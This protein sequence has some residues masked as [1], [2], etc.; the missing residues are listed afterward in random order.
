MCVLGTFSEV[1]TVPEVL[2]EA[3]VLLEATATFWY[4]LAEITPIKI[5]DKRVIRTFLVM[6]PTAS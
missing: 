1:R 4:T 3:E 2:I 6:N 5:N